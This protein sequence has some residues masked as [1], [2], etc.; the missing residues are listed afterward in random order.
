MNTKQ[1]QLTKTASTRVNTNINLK[2]YY[3][4]YSS[5]FL[6]NHSVAYRMCV[7]L[8][9]F[10]IK[11]KGKAST[12]SKHATLLLKLILQNLHNCTDF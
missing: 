7:W 11:L 2:H 12:V 8:Y 9:A 10:V 5:V 4:H 1:I 3:Y 6:G